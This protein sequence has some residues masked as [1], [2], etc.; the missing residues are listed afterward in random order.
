MANATTVSENMESEK[1][2]IGSRLEITS[3]ISTEHRKV[4]Q[5]KNEKKKKRK[6]GQQLKVH[7]GNE[8]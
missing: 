7:I 3:H 5:M 6:G 2:Q 4:S 8:T 1:L